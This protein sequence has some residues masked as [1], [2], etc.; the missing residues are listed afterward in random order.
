MSHVLIKLG[1]TESDPSRRGFGRA[2]LPQIK[3]GKGSAYFGPGI[4]VRR[5]FGHDSVGSARMFQRLAR[6]D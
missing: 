5:K 3:H 4:T 6:R 2:S 1:G